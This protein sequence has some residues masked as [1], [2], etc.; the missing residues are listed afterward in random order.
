VLA[1]SPMADELPPSVQLVQ[2]ATAHWVSRIVRVAA[3]L[4]IA[5]HLA[6]GPRTAEVL[7][8]TTGTHAP[9]LYRFLRTLASL[10]ILTEDETHAFG[11]TPL[12]EALRKGAPG[13]ARASI[14]TLA[15]EWISRG[16]DELRYSVETGKSG[17]E[18]SLGMPIFD[19]LAQH[20]EQASL[21]SE[22]M[23]GVHGSEP[24]TVAAAYDFS[25]LATVVDV[26]GASG[27]LLTTILGRHPGPR[28][29]LF[30]L[31]HVVRDAPALIASRG[32][33]DRVTIEPGSFFEKVP[34][35]GDAYLLSH[36]IHDWSE[37]QCIAI[38]GNCR[39]AMKPGS[40]LLIIE[41]VLPPGDTPHP[42]KMLD[43][44]MLVGPGGQ[45]RTEP[46]YKALLAKA[47]F[48]L[49]RVVPTASPVSVVEA[50]HA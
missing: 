17:V 16:M 33:K 36:I 22:T 21:F 29:I 11:L 4:D 34:E 37:D 46:E 48:R 41:M 47:G 25:D 23:I 40:R 45:E 43:M 1:S 42:G 18:K 39:R 7:A 30:D 5:D 14:L 10:G 3:E 8:G 32:L 9:S 2:M 6:E 50:V 49:A 31:P 12:G 15:G 44:M 20:P 13:C 26:G 35:G 27:N 28:G 24:A 19:W 38:L